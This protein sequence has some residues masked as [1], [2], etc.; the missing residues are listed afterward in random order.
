MHVQKRILTNF[1]ILLNSRIFTNFIMVKLELSLCAR[2]SYNEHAAARNTLL[3]TVGR[4][5]LGRFS[6]SCGPF[7]TCVGPFWTSMWAVLSMSK[8]LVWAV[9]V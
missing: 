4:F 7:C 6:H 1:K 5:A 3:T 8:I 2:H 9:F